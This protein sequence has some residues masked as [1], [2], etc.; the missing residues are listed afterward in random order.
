MARMKVVTG[1]ASNG[2]PYTKMGQ[3]SETIVIFDGLDFMHQPPTGLLLRMTDGSFRRLS[4]SYTVYLVERKPG[5]P[6]GY[7]IQDMANDNANWIRKEIRQ[8]VDILGLSTGGPIAQFFAAEHPD[9]TKHLVLASTGYRLSDKGRTMQRETGELAKQH[10]WRSAYARMMEGMVSRVERL[11][12]VPLF[13]LFGIHY[14][15]RP[16]SPSDALV[17]IEAEENHDFKD[18]LADI[19]VP[20][21]V[22]GGAKDDLYPIAE[23]AAGIPGA[24]LILY[25]GVGHGAYLKRQFSQDVL[26]FLRD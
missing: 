19:Q 7:T 25:P 15:G 2:V 22:I 4:R 24:R 17:E 12:Y 16:K 20:T 10:K 11:L 6:K 1:Y 23:T 9:L 13:W 26:A 5:L 21:L 18:R 3:G 14:F 8:P